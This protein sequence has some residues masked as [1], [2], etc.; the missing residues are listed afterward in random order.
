VAPNLPPGIDAWW[1]RAAAR[2]PA[3]RFQSAKE[4]VEALGSALDISSAYARPSALYSQPYAGMPATTPS[5]D[6]RNSGDARYS[7]G[8]WTPQGTPS[9]VAPTTGDPVAQLSFGNGEQPRDPPVHATVPG[10]SHTMANDRA[11]RVRVGVFVGGV[12]TVGAVGAVVALGA[13]FFGGGGGEDTADSAAPAASNAP[14]VTETA[15]PA[16]SSAAPEVVPDATV[17]PTARP[18][19]GPDKPVVTPSTSKPGAPAA[20]A[21]TTAPAAPAKT[22]APAAPAKTGSKPF[23]PG[24]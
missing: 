3:H 24:F 11:R 10:I 4:L 9:G 5:G 19:A 20:P 2:D 12:V 13:A 14:A 22:T 7:G 16:A 21:K 18:V 15:A 1:A 6:A 17:E 23:N 8:Q